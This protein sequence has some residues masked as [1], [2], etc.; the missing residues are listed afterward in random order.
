MPRVKPF[1]AV[2]PVPENAANV[3]SVPYDVVNRNEA[4]ELAEGNADS[5]LHVIRPDI[6]L[7]SGT[8]PYSAEIYAKAKENFDRFLA[9]GVLKQDDT[10]SIFLYRQIMDGKSQIGIVCC[11]HVDDYENNCILK[12]EKTRPAKEDD[13]TRHIMTLGAHPGPLFLAYKDHDTVNA[14]VESAITE[15]PLVDFT[16]PDG[17]QHTIWQVTDC[18]GYVDALTSVPAFYICL[19]YTSPSPRD[20]TLSRMPSSA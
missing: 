14:A 2:R 11:C 16:A 8:D 4:A 19:L 20:A 12:H 13:R 17:V 9:D 18:D 7:P 1:R 15:A 6:D 5:F 10:A 3:A